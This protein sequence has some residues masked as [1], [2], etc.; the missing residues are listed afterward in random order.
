MRLR[1][2]LPSEVATLN[3]AL[4]ALENADNDTDGILGRSGAA[5]LRGLPAAGSLPKAQALLEAAA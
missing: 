2:L 4:D 3:A 5:V 1:G